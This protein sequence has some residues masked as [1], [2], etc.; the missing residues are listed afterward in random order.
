MA[1]AGE[2]RSAAELLVRV[3][4]MDADGRA[5]FQN[6]MARNLSAE[7]AQ[8][9]GIDH[10][11][12]V[13]EIIGVQHGDKKA[14]V[15]VA[16][17]SDAGLPGKIVADVRIV[18]GQPC[19]WEGLTAAQQKNE[20]E[21]SLRSNQRQFRRVKTRFPLELRDERGRG[22]SMQTNSSDIT[23]RGCYIET[24]VP[25]PLGTRLNVTFWIESTKISTTGIVRSS[26]PGVGMGVEFTGLNEETKERFQRHL[27][28]LADI[29][30]RPQNPS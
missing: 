20:S 29:P 14:R 22:T 17:V 24:L 27:E 18:S 28:S 9:T 8:L 13:G 19:P 16:G 26:D 12:K 30:M 23:G 1:K 5:F 4:G 15:K 21:G 7:G 25:L 3:W 11:L 10:A 2:A 6:A